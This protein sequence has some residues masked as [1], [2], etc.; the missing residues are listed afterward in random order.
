M[1]KMM[2]DVHMEVVIIREE[3]GID[4]N[5]SKMRAATLLLAAALL[6]T[7]SGCSSI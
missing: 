1:G 3:L 2:G 5:R 7:V 6:L 4:M